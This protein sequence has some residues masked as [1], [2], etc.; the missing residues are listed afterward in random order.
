MICFRNGLFAVLVCC[1]AMASAEAAKWQADLKIAANKKSPNHAPVSVAV[2]LPEALA[3]ATVAQLVWDDGRVDWGQITHPSLAGRTKG[4]AA[5]VPAGHV[6]RELWFIVSGLASKETIGVEVTVDSEL[7]TAKLA[8]VEQFHWQETAGKYSDLLLGDRTLLRYM[9]EPLDESRREE[10]YKVYHQVF[11]PSGK[12]LL[13]K[14]PGGLFPHHRGIYFGFNQINYG[15]GRSADT[16]HCHGK[17]HQSHMEFVR[18]EAGP[19]LGRHVVK[20]GWHGQEGEVFA[21]ELRE[22]TV[23][24]QPKTDDN[25]TGTLIEFASQ[26]STTDGEIKLDGD[27]Q[28]AGVQFRAAAEVA[29]KTNGQTYYVRTDGVGKPGEYRNWDERKDQ[30]NFPWKGMSMVVEDRRYTVANLDHPQNPK[31]AR[32][33]ERDYGRFGSY[34]AAKV[35]P[36][37]PLNVNYRYWVQ[38]GEMT[39]DQIAKLSDEFVNPPSVTVT[40]K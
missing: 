27:P 8:K 36:E 31:E 9:H 40:T 30:I 3:D 34:F 14:G 20:V 24:R 26:L 28:H 35:T 18:E 22:L 15:D 10:T 7:D 29:D 16:W 37:Q 19:V 4:E 25:P 21:E 33:S 6:A 2:N 13:T 39:P 17:A 5:E 12:T 38:P 1:L 23:F 11:D 32:F